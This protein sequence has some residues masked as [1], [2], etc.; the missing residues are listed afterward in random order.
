MTTL[1]GGREILRSAKDLGRVLALAYLAGPGETDAWVRAGGSRWRPAFPTAGAHWRS[2]PGMACMSSRRGWRMRST[3][4]SPSS[5]ARFA[6]GTRCVERALLYRARLESQG[7]RVTRRT[8]QRDIERLSRSL[9]LACDD[10]RK[11]YRWSWDDSLSG[12]LR[13]VIERVTQ[14]WR[15]SDP[16]ISGVSSGCRPEVSV[17]S[18]GW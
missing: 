14:P 12:S 17:R 16:E 13:T 5:G 6:M 4:R 7:I 9:P 2:A 8:L 3:A 10:T 15:P 11:P 1:I 18:A